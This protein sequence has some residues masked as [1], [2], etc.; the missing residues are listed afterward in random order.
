MVVV[1]DLAVVVVVAGAARH[2]PVAVAVVAAAVAAVAGQ[3][4]PAVGA[5]VAAAVVA[6]VAVARPL[7]VAARPSAEH[8]RTG[9]PR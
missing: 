9:S 2:D 6:A 5:P 7:R 1:A 3:P 8:F 4:V